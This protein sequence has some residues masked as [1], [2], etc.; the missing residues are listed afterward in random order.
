MVKHLWPLKDGVRL[1]P[2]TDGVY[3]VVLALKYKIPSFTKFDGMG[4]LMDH[5][6]IFLLSVKTWS[7]LTRNAMQWFN[8]CL[9]RSIGGKIHWLQH[10][11]KI[12]TKNHGTTRM[13]AMRLPRVSIHIDN[14]GTLKTIQTVDWT[15][16][17]GRSDHTNDTEGARSCGE[18][19]VRRL[20]SFPSKS[21]SSYLHM[22]SSRRNQ[23]RFFW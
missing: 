8:N 3:D 10:G 18:S 5:I 12:V 2:L 7:S 6:S 21:W 11:G 20:F 16:A 9:Y 14:G 22:P 19:I 23:S 13:E 15:H 17:Q 1:W 4:K